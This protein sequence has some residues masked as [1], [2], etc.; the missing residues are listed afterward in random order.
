VL[1]LQ[2]R[3]PLQNMVDVQILVNV[4]HGFVSA[5]AAPGADGSP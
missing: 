2:G 1:Q 3:A 5:R 4:P